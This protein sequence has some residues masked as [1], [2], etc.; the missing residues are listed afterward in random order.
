M[1][2]VRV[3]FTFQTGIVLVH[4]QALKILKTPEFM[5]YVVFIA[6]PPIDT[7]VEIHKRSTSE[8]TI[9]KKQTVSITSPCLHDV[10][11][12]LQQLEFPFPV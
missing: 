2:L 7:L 11:I 1:L 3:L 12:Q 4:L 5:P 8:G 10:A 6:S 9:T